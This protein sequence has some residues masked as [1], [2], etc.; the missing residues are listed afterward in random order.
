MRAASSLTNR[1]FLACTLLAMLS[2]G[3]AFYFVNERASAEAEADLRRGLVEAG[4][5]VDQYGATRIDHFHAAG[6]R[7]RRPAQAE[8]GRRDRR[9]ADRPAAR[10]RVP[11]RSGRRPARADRPRRRACSEPRAPTTRRSRRGGTTRN[12]SEEIS[13]FT[14][15][16]RGVLQMVSVPILLEGERP[17]ILGRLTVGVFLD[18]RGGR[19]RSRELTGSE[20]AFGAEGRI[21]ASTLPPVR[22]RRAGAG[23]DRHVDRIGRDRRRGVRRAGAAAACRGDGTHRRHP[24]SR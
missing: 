19:A 13:T 14:P 1:V 16:E 15:H 11:D 5:L 12:R 4:T 8:G 3:F 20:I 23:D 7:R 18:D 2:L 24:A 17:E 22:A 9:S 10:R 21:L 6:A